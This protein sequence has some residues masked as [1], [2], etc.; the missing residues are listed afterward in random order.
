[1]LTATASR[2]GRVVNGCTLPG[3]DGAGLAPLMEPLVG[4]AAAAVQFGAARMRWT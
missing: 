2:A 3:K 1:M 4:A